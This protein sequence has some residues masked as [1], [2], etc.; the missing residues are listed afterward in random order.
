MIQAEVTFIHLLILCTGD[1]ELIHN[2]VQSLIDEADS[3]TLPLTAEHGEY[4]LGVVIHIHIFLE[5]LLPL[6]WGQQ[7]LH[8]L[9]AV[10]SVNDG[11]RAVVGHQIEEAV[12]DQQLVR[13]HHIELHYYTLALNQGSQEYGVMN[14]L[15][16]CYMEGKGT[17]QNLAKAEELLNRAIRLGSKMAKD[18]LAI[19][20]SYNVQKVQTQLASQGRTASTNVQADKNRRRD[21]RIFIVLFAILGIL[22]LGVLSSGNDYDDRTCAWCNGTGYSANGAKTAEE[23]VF[24][25][26][27]CTHCNGKGTYD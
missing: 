3:Y 27:P 26:T 10:D 22:I 2:G 6:P 4:S 12:V 13:I 24:K 20:H 8:I 16:V 25:K 9:H 14:N 1:A 15:G 23:Y 17:T 5:L 11:L 21:I 18:N 19:L 7:F